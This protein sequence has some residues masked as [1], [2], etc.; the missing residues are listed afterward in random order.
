M[1]RG[2]TLIVKDGYVTPNHSWLS[3]INKRA[4]RC[5]L[6]A[7]T[8]E[9]VREREA[10]DAQAQCFRDPNAASVCEAR[11]VGRIKLVD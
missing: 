5:G 10:A 4:S 11:Y 1:L 2:W 8:Q 6:A 3:G 9:H 7:K